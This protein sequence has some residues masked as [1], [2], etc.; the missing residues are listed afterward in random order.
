MAAATAA[1]ETHGA[2]LPQSPPSPPHQNSQHT[3][4]HTRTHT[5]LVSSSA[6]R[7]RSPLPHPI[8]T[9][10]HA[11]PSPRRPSL[12]RWQP[13]ASRRVAHYLQRSCS[14]PSNGPDST[15][16]RH[17]KNSARRHPEVCPRS[18]GAR[19]RNSFVEICLCRQPTPLSSA[20]LTGLSACGSV[21]V[22]CCACRLCQALL[23]CVSLRQPSTARLYV[24][25]RRRK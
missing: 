11:F 7:P 6:P 9:L 21:C 24:R 20:A 13:V 2:P 23:C 22:C 15:D 3:H 5:S 17:S 10:F 25:F 1:F 18:L 16:K 4:K 19:L 14:R 8:S 12:C